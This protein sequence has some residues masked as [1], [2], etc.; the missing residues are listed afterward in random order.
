[1]YY[2]HVCI[3]S[4]LRKASQSKKVETVFIDFN[5]KNRNKSQIKC[6]HQNVAFV[7]NYEPINLTQKPGLTTFYQYMSE[8]ADADYQL[9]SG[10][11]SLI[12]IYR[13]YSATANN[14]IENAA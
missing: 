6:S 1:V 2:R 11:A 14:T 3:R 4:T 9:I 13:K 7:T 12:N 5:Y 8:L 10:G